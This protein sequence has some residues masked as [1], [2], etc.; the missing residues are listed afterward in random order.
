MKKG[1]VPIRRKLRGGTPILMSAKF[2]N[3]NLK[4]ENMKKL[5]ALLLALTMV[6]ALCACGQTAAP[7][8]SAAPAEESAAPEAPAQGK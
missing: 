4:E 3:Q 8:E 1:D 6:F 2:F 7:A 5:L